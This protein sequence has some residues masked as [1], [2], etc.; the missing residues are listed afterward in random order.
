VLL[1]ELTVHVCGQGI[2][3]ADFETDDVVVSCHAAQMGEPYR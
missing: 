3:T 2:W 1:A